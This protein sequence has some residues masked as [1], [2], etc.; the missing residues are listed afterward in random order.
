MWNIPLSDINF[1]SSE[2]DAVKQIL[3]GGWLT[4][5]DI[6][7][8]FEKEFAQFIGT[9]HAI[10]VSS[11]TAA[12]HLGMLALKIKPGDEV[13]CPSFSFVASGNAI[14]YTGAKPVFADIESLDNLTI[15]VADIEKKITPKTKAI[16][17]VH[18]AGQPCKMAQISEIAKQYN[19]EII[20]DCAHAPG[21]RYNG[22]SCGTLGGIGCFSFFSNKNMTTAEGGMI[23]TNRDDLA[24][25]IRLM[26]SHG[27]TSL[28][29]DRHKGNGFSYDVTALGYNYRIDEIRSAI[30][31]AQLHKISQANRCRGHISRL[32]CNNLKTVEKISLPFTATQDDLTT[33]AHHIFPIILSHSLDRNQFMA[34]MKD[35]KIQTSIHYPPMHSLTYYRHKL[36]YNDSDLPV[37]SQAGLREVTLPLF[38]TMSDNDV[39]KVCECIKNFIASQG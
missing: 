11:G 2:I 18:F 13:I 16:E 5:G 7:K 25:S 24:E 31:I 34:W 28:T 8:Q 20:E 22:K 30:G 17:V 12:L 38:P 36:Q 27:M 33:S 15:S 26:R 9:R 37:T 3:T 23:T 1:D 32:Y 4:M 39:L 6:T 19:L 10:A 35:H 29:L 21:A 14:L